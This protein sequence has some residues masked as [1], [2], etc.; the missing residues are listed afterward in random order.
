MHNLFMDITI[1]ILRL[2]DFS[3]YILNIFSSYSV[4]VVSI[5]PERIRV[6]CNYII[7]QIKL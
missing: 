4:D 6:G 5:Y 2:L 1:Y 7:K 3:S